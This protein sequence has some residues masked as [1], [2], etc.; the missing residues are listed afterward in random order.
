MHC[1]LS[2]V[3]VIWS[4]TGLL[5]NFISDFVAYYYPN[6]YTDGVL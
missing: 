6:K 1:D 2:A 4:F 5:A 3:S